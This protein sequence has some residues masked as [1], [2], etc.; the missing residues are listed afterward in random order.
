MLSEEI[1]NQ[2]RG[3]ITASESHSMMTGWDTPRPTE[4]F[5]TEIYEWMAHTGRRPLVGE[6][7][8]VME[9]DVNTKAIEA[10]WKAYRFDQPT[11]GLITYAEKLACD[12]L[13]ERDPNDYDGPGTQ[14][15]INGNERE[16]DAMIKLSDATGI[17]FKR[18]GEDQIHISTDGIGVTPDGVAYDDLDLIYAGAEAKCRSPLH[19]ARQLLIV[20]NATLLDHDFDRYCQIQTGY[21]ATGAQEWYSV[22]YNPCALNKADQ[23]HYCLIERD[24]AFIKVLMQRAAD[25]FKHK[26]AFI[27]TISKGRPLREKQQP[28]KEAA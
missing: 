8:P 26:Q 27:E 22:S 13:F 15:M 25:V 3:N 16:I 20:D 14:D 7:K 17:D 4:P 11:Q 19:H 12:E 28:Q 6:I 23:F 10:A 1:I 21:V 2:R 9:C 18:T 24:E 5:E